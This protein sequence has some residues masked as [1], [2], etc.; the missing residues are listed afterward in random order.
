MAMNLHEKLIQDL[1]KCLKLC[2]YQGRKV[3]QLYWCVYH[4]VVMSLR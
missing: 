4:Q 2:N 3:F 1:E